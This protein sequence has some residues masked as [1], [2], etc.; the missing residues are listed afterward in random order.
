MV[1]R[2]TAITCYETAIR[3]CTIVNEEGL[4]QQ[5]LF[6]Q[7][8]GAILTPGEGPAF[9]HARHLLSADMHESREREDARDKELMASIEAAMACPLP[10]PA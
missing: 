3:T 9:Q 4:Y 10:R 5:D 7:R 6:V 8:F 1:A 2:C